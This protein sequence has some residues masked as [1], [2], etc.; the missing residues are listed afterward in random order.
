MNY[1]IKKI[2]TSKLHNFSFVWNRHISLSWYKN[3]CLDECLGLTKA[4]FF[5]GA[6]AV[7]TT[8]GRK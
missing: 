8:Q 1:K 4:W 3:Q 7:T 5:G 6:M 2:S